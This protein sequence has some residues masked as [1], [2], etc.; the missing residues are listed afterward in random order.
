MD[1]GK[2]PVEEKIEELNARIKDVK[3]RVGEEAI[4]ILEE[5]GINT[6]AA[7]GN[8][9]E[10]AIIEESKTDDMLRNPM[11]AEQTSMTSELIYLIEA[12]CDGSGL[13]WHYH[14]DL[15]WQ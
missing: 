4:Q 15:A 3:A 13:K 7:I 8:V 2:K 9:V 6:D 1:S 11:L 12:G 5:S 14:D 10:Q